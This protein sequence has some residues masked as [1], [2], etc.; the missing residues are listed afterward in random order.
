MATLL[1][2]AMHMAILTPAASPYAA[3]LIGNKDW[4]DQSDVLKYGSVILVATFAIFLLVGLPL[5]RVMF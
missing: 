1:T 3:I 4:V 2:F 5:S